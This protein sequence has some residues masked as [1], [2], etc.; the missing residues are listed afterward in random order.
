MRI[1]SFYNYD[2]SEVTYEKGGGDIIAVPD[3]SLSVREILERF[4]RGTLTEE[5]ISMR[6]FYDDD[7]EEDI[8]EF[9]NQIEDLTDLQNIIDNAKQRKK[10]L[11]ESRKSIDVE[12][13]LSTDNES[14]I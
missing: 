14:Q 10:D 11:E 8:E 1:I 13:S 12:S 3:Q 6:G 2:P 7:G 9:V 5:E 4:R